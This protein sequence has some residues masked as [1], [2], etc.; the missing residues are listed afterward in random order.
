MRAKLITVGTSHGSDVFVRY[1][2]NNVLF[3]VELFNDARG[4]EEK[5]GSGVAEPP[6]PG[7]CATDPLAWASATESP[8]LPTQNPPRCQGGFQES[9][10]GF[11]EVFELGRFPG[12]KLRS[13]EGFELGR[14]P[15]SKSES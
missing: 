10:Y 4:L 15:G 14:F 13:W 2:L 7:V 3:H 8:W 11:K 5:L 12:G 1:L 9:K 6:T